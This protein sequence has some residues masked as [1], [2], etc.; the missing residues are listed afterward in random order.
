MKRSVIIIVCSFLV[1]CCGTRTEEVV[2]VGVEK[3]LELTDT[4]RMTSVKSE[5]PILA[6][7]RLFVAADHLVLYQV[8]VE[9]RFQIYD[10]PLNGR[11]F[12]A[13]MI[14]RG[15]DEFIDPDVGSMLGCDGGFF[16]ADQDAFKTVEILDSTVK[17]TSKIPASTDGA[18]LNGVIKVKDKYV[19]VD[20]YAMTPGFNP[21]GPRQFQVIGPDGVEKRI[22]EL[23]NWNDNDDNIIRYFSSI[24]A[25]PDDNMFAAFYGFNFRKI[26]YYNL[27][28][29]VLKEVS[30]D[31]PDNSIH[32][33]EEGF[34]TYGKSFASKNRIVVI[35]NNYSRKS[36][37]KAPNYSE[38]QVWDWTG[39]LIHRL[40]VPMK[41]GI[42]TVDFSTGTLYA[43]SGGSEDE[44][45]YCDIS[46]YL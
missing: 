22:A 18:T 16:V 21:E 23:P 11:C 12:S 43:T 27:D 15:P 35:C 36:R 31:F 28:G 42:Y 19:N 17:V 7:A 4:V 6:P 5:L 3:A 20:V 9:K 46:E 26:R 29:D 44:I 25:K 14:G 1:V 39:H 13:G 2:S 33:S 41:L 37:D 32:Q 38:F 10:L 34:L 8:Q 45:F 24:V 30:A 40:I